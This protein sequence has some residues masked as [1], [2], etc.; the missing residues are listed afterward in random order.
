MD[1]LIGRLSPVKTASFVCKSSDSIILQSEFILS[2]E[3][4]TTT[5]PGTNSEDGISKRIPF[6]MTFD[7][8]II[9][10]LRLIIALSALY[11]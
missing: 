9:N 2:P 5:S 4:K 8:G 7:F 10:F 6:L 1:L 11:C 3:F